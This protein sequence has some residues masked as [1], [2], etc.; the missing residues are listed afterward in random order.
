[1]SD[2]LSRRMAY[3]NSASA[4]FY[5]NEITAKE[6]K[7]VEALRAYHAHG[8]VIHSDNCTSDDE[9]RTCPSGSDFPEIIK[10][11]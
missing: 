11:D 4:A 7:N 10:K 1:M 5:A 9:I 8:Y 2:I 3:R 6:E